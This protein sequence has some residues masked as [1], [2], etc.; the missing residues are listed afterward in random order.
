MRQP[1]N[2]DQPVAHLVTHR[3][4]AIEQRLES[5]PSAAVCIS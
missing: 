4:Q 3:K 1:G 5:V 2:A